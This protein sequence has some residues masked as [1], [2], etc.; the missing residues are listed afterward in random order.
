[1]NHP[2]APGVR[3]RPAVRFRFAALAAFALGGGLGGVLAVAAPTPPAPSTGPATPAAKKAPAVNV[4]VSR[5]ATRTPDALREAL[6][7]ELGEARSAADKEGVRTVVV[8]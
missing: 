8:L 4:P 5:P 3:R 1:M 6:E 2:A 7:A